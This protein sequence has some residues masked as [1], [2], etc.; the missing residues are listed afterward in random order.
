MPQAPQWVALVRVSVSQ[1][2]VVLPS[3]SA[4]GAVQLPTPQTPLRQT[5]VAF[6]TTQR[7]PQLPQFSVLD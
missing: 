7:M 4:K 2:F 1:P 6:G 3:Q 5:G